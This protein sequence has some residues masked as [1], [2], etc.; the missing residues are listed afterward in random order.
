MNGKNPVDG[1]RTASFVFLGARG[2]IC[3]TKIPRINRIILKKYKKKTKHPLH[4]RK[5]YAKI[6][7]EKEKTA[8]AAYPRIVDSSITSRSLLRIVGGSFFW[9]KDNI[10]QHN[11]V[12]DSLDCFH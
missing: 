8:T 1:T 3:T 5:K 2:C 4:M 7:T 11:N 9:S 6:R 10:T 12:C